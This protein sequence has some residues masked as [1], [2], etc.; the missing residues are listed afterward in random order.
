M[1]YL[2]LTIFQPIMIAQACRVETIRKHKP[3]LLKGLMSARADLGE[4]QCT[5]TIRNIDEG[6]APLDP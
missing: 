1:T 4:I 3:D 2:R 5:S 6:D